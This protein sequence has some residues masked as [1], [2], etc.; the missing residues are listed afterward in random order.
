MLAHRIAPGPVEYLLGLVMDRYSL[1]LDGPA[2]TSGALW[3]PQR[4]G[5]RTHRLP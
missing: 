2:H 3:D 1:R 5:H 4:S